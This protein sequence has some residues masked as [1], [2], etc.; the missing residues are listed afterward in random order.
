MDYL[1]LNALSTYLKSQNKGV[2]LNELKLQLFS[3]PHTPSLLAITDTLDFL[4]IKNVAAQIDHDQ[5]DFLPPHF[6]A[7]IE[8]KNEGDFF[9]HVEKKG[10]KVYL[11]TTKELDNPEDFKK[12]WNGIVLVAEKESVL[13]SS[14]YH[15]SQ[16]GI[17]LLLLLS[18]VFFFPRFDLILFSLLGI[19]GIVLSHEIFKTSNDRSSQLGKKICGEKE[20][21]GCN[22]ILTSTKYHIGPFSPNDFLFA[23]LASVFAHTI[24][25]SG[26]TYVVYFLYTAALLVV[27]GTVVIQAFFAKKWCRLCLL[28]SLVLVCQ[29]I[30]LVFNPFFEQFLSINVNTMVFKEFA[31]L[32]LLFLFSLVLIKNYR[33]TQEQNYTLNASQFELLSFKRN[34]DTITSLLATSH[35]IP[36]PHCSDALVLKAPTPTTQLQIQ[37]IISTTCGFCKKAFDN[38][39]D[40]ITKTDSDHSLEIIFNHYETS[41]S[42][43]NDVAAILIHAYHHKGIVRFLELAAQWFTDQNKEDFL[44]A[45]GQEFSNTDYEI[46]RKHRGWCEENKLYNT[47][48]LLINGKLIP[49]SYDTS[50][51][52]DLTEVMEVDHVHSI[53]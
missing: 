44:A 7:F 48:T 13:G 23:F 50:F 22:Q 19:V 49:Y 38:Y 8:D 21:R 24:I 37:L 33:K 14:T 2:S 17:P 32:L 43:K 1:L 47:P 28:C 35:T 30:L 36:F 15:F 42:E 3:H 16:W 9:S 10:S 18:L 25:Q 6:I 53:N 31:S 4:N 51:L 29:S 5:L 11:H 45:N 34:A 39:Y 52:Q 41:S 26:F 20:D 12:R 27:A 40:F 46:L